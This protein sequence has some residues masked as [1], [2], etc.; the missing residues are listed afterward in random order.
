LNGA[1]ASLS[2]LGR[3]LAELLTVD[4]NQTGRLTIVERAQVQHLLDEIRLGQTGSVDPATAARAGRLLGAGRI[5]QGRLDGNESELRIQAMVVA[6]PATAQ[7]RPAPVTQRGALRELFAMQNNV[8]L[9]LYRTL[10]VELTVAERE[11]VLRQPTQNVQALLAF[12]IGLEAEDAGRLAEAAGHYRRAAA[13]DP[14]FAEADAA[15]ERAEAGS[16]AAGIS[17]ALLATQSLGE[18]GPGPATAPAV[19]SLRDRLVGLD[20]IVP[21]FGR[22]DPVPELLGSDSFERRALLELLIIRPR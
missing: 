14:A 10:G 3:A 1:G 9:D 4:L 19:V 13:L 8:A 5:V 22:R 20:A 16:A 7:A 17:P 15:L 6:V 18:L 12:G 2:P 11:R 21:G